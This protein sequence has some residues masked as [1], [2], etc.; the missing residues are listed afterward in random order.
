MK[1]EAIDLY[2]KL[3]S[4]WNKKPQNLANCTDLLYKLKVGL[5]FCKLCQSW[6][7]ITKL[8]KHKIKIMLTEIGFIPTHGNKFDKKDLHLARKLK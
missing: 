6:H 7:F 4:E 2:N 3:T 5:L 1:Q 8:Y